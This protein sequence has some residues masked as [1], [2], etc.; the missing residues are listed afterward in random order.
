V[1]NL[2]LFDGH[3]VLDNFWFMNNFLADHFF[4][5]G[6]LNPAAVLQTKT[7]IERGTRTRRVSKGRMGERKDHGKHMGRFKAGADRG[8]SATK[9]KEAPGGSGF[10][11][12]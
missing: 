10:P 3:S 1:Q 5:P 12:P 6:F 7:K 11:R 9:Q 2:L 4:V 8:D